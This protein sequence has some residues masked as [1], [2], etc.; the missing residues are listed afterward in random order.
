[1]MSN[2]YTITYCFCIIDYCDT[3]VTTYDDFYNSILML[4]GLIGAIP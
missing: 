2:Y 4:I 1:M 3:D